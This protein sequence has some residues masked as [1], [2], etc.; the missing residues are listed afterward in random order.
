MKDRD[1]KGVRAKRKVILSR[2][3]VAD[4]RICDGLLRFR[5]T[6]VLVADVLLQVAE[7]MDFEAISEHWN[8]EV[9]EEAIQEAVL[10]AREALLKYWPE[11]AVEE[12]EDEPE[13][14]PAKPGRGK[15]ARSGSR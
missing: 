6:H 5:G 7:G 10:L 15:A 9:S 4:P 13:A 12:P 11:M 2:Y 3:V 8:G 1:W 14:P